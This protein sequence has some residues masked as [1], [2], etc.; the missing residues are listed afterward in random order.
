MA[1]TPSVTNAPDEVLRPRQDR[2]GTGPHDTRSGPFASG[3]ALEVDGSLGAAMRLLAAVPLLGLALAVP[4][5]ASPPACRR[6]DAAMVV[7]SAAVVRA[8]LV[9]VSRQEAGTTRRI[10][11]QFRVSESLKGRLKPG[12]RATVEASCLAEPVPRDLLGYPGAA[13]YCR[14]GVGPGLTGV[15]PSGDL[16]SP[17]PAAGW[18]LFLERP[19]D[20]DWSEVS[21]AGYGGECQRDAA[22]LSARDR[23]AIERLR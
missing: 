22:T 9:S 3:P 23:R 7:A 5:L 8:E 10:Q 17:A 14:S 18:L 15:D 16:V 2:P 4:V 20:G 21:R 12:Q 11:G 1:V 19:F 13:R 6:D